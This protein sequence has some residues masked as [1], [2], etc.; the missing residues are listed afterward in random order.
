M[1][2]TL[3]YAIEKLQRG[4][5]SPRDCR[6]L[7]ELLRTCLPSVEDSQEDCD[8]DPEYEVDTM[9]TMEDVP[10]EEDE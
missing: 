5:L 3:N 2:D 10:W 6:E 1:I 8:P 7:A 4:K 9:E